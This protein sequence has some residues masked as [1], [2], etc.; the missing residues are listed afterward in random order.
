[1]D[2]K[3]ISDVLYRKIK[4]TTKKI[5]DEEEFIKSVSDFMSATYKD[6]INEKS[7]TNEA[8]IKL[9]NI[10]DDMKKEDIIEEA[11]DFP[12]TEFNLKKNEKMPSVCYDLFIAAKL[13]CLLRYGDKKHVHKKL[14]DAFS[15]KFYASGHK[16]TLLSI[17]KPLASSFVENFKRYR[18]GCF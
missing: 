5:M 17:Y 15:S 9:N 4:T 11:K 12:L 18:K 8:K 3:T 14:I 1:M 7:N 13:Y 2:Q 10:L 16:E 6:A